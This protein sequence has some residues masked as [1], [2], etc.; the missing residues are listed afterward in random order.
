MIKI[1]N[2]IPSPVNLVTDGSTRTVSLRLG[3]MAYVKELAKAPI[4]GSVYVADCLGRSLSSCANTLGGTGWMSLR[5]EQLGYRIWKI[6]EPQSRTR[7]KGA[8]G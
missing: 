6:A 7:H 8:E 3:P 1:D 4:G 2:D 5:K